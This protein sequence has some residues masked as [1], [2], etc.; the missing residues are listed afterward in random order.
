[1]SDTLLALW[2]PLFALTNP[3]LACR[4]PVAGRHLLRR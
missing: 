1:M 3:L 2:R 4:L